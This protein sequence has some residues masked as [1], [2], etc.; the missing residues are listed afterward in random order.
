MGGLILINR[1]Y[2]IMQYNTIIEG[3]LIFI[4]ALITSNC[5]FLIAKPN[6][7]F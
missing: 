1:A 2:L 6:D 4:T 7:V 5:K 3:Y